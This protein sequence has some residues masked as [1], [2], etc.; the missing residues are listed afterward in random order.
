MEYLLIV[1]FLVSLILT[2]LALPKW[3]VKCKKIGLLWE[4]M[5]KPD[6]NRNVAASGGVIVVMTFVLGVLTYIAIRTFIM[7]GDGVNVQIFALLTVILLFAIVGLV[8]DL[9]GWKHGGLSVRIRIFLAFVASI[10]LVVI[11]AGNASMNIPFIGYV[12]LGLLYP[13]VLIPI[14]IAG[15]AITFNFLAGFNGLEAGQGIIII[16]F[17][18]FI[19]YIT[20][21]GWL[22]IIG[23][24][25]VAS[26]SVFYFYNKVPAK[27]FPGDI[28]TY[29]VGALMAGMAI[30]GDFERIAVFVFIPYIL[31]T[32]L[33]LRGGLRKQSFAKPNPDGSLEMPYKKIYGL[34]H[35]SLF[36][37]KK[38]KRKV[39]END[40]IY[41]IFIFQ[42]FICLIALLIAN[43]WIF[44]I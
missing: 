23:L 8:D 4:D 22:A 15:A 1:A 34:T 21:S 27:V 35:L 14:G 44:S 32:G 10:P 24:C 18:S 28:L 16:S 25:M 33:K 39:Y 29:S 5:N 20:N 31:E 40:V 11:N 17:L 30:L 12:S 13:L 41:L 3:I 36:I 19:A 9:L 6:K 38:F 2:W 7:Q 42:I 26:L 37:L 43:R